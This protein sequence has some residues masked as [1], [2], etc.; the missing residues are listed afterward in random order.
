VP[1]QSHGRVLD[2]THR[3]GGDAGEV[4]PSGVSFDEEQDVESAQADSIYA[5]R[6]RGLR[7]AG[8]HGENRPARDNQLGRID[9]IFG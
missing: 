9:G 8:V 5:G 1:G 3:A 2:G 6:H 4:D 7:R